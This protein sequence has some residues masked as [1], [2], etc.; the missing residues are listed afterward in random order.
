MYYKDVEYV[1][2]VIVYYKDVEYVTY[3]IVYYKDVEYVTYVIVYH[4]KMVN[5]LHTSLCIIVSTNSVGFLYR[6]GISIN[7]AIFSLGKG[8]HHM[9]RF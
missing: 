7:L 2:Y 5:M 9:E 1:T 8:S 3:V 4:C 6:G